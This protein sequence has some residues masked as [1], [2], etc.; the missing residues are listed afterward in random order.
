MLFFSLPLYISKRAAKQYLELYEENELQLDRNECYRQKK[1]ELLRRAF[2]SASRFAVFIEETK[3]TPYT[4]FR[5]GKNYPRKR[6]NTSSI[7]HDIKFGDYMYIAIGFFDHGVSRKMEEVLKRYRDRK[8]LILDLRNNTGGS[9]EECMKISR[10]LLPSC[11][12]AE[13]RYPGKTIIYT[14]DEARFGFQRIFILVNGYTA[15]CGEILALTLRAHLNEAAV[16]GNRTAG[17]DIGQRTFNHRKKRILFTVSSFYWTVE[18]GNSHKLEEYLEKDNPS[19][20]SFLSDDDY[21]RHIHFID[22]F[23][24]GG[25]G[26]EYAG[27]R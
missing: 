14:S 4:C 17:K 16:I 21:Y 12:I 26:Q 8:G 13:L 23:A 9:I 10:L 3:G 20:I 6:R 22:S 2:I 19:G 18:G 5:F 24:A 27:E 7:E 11:D 1:T 25:Q 15:S